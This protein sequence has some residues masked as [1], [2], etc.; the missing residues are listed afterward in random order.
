M[1]G[2]DQVEQVKGQFTHEE[3]AKLVTEVDRLQL[4]TSQY[5]RVV[6]QKL[7][8]LEEN[9]ELFARENSRL[10]AVKDALMVERDSCT[11]L[12][13][14]LAEKSGYSVGKT[15]DSIVVVNLPSGQVS[16]PFH[17]DEKHLFADLPDYIGAVETIEM[18]ELYTRV[19]NP[20][21]EAT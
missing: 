3:V 10:L 20:G 8:I 16:W 14:K 21:L 15:D 1:M 12:I 6:E 17:P 9:L 2:N 5:T 19:M 4:E 11:S 13:A 18:V 7:K